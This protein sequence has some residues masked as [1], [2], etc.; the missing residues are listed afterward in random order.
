MG[1]AQSFDGDVTGNHFA[2][3]FWIVKLN[4]LGNIQWQKALGGNGTEDA[5]SV[6]QTVDGDF[7]IAGGS[8]SGYS[9]DVTYNHGFE[10]YW[11]VKL[12]ANVGI[13]D[14]AAKNEIVIYPNPSYDRI[15]IQIPQCFGSPKGLEIFNCI[16][17]LQLERTD[18]FTDIDINS[19]ASGLYF[20]VL[21][22]L[23]NERLTSKILKE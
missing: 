10:D 21:T 15:N 6:Q 1:I 18:N 8:S 9:G 5:Y 2:G 4:S 12:S 7:I 16:G 19:L 20:I 14:Y 22:N 23:D 3:D 11:V 17:Q 13:S